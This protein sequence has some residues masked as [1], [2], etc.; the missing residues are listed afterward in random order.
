MVVIVNRLGGGWVVA[1]VNRLVGWLG[2]WWVGG[3]S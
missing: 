1:I 2:G 3:D